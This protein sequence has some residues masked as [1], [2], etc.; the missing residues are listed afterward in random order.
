MTSPS[1]EMPANAPLLEGVAPYGDDIELFSDLY[2]MLDERLAIMVEELPAR[3]RP[4]EI[5]FRGL[6]TTDAE[7]RRLL[8]E[9]PDL[10]KSG[11]GEGLWQRVEPRVLASRQQG[12]AL[13][14][15]VVRERFLL[16]NFETECLV[17]C[18][19]PEMDA[20][21]QKLYGYLN[22]DASQR[23]PSVDLLLRLLAPGE[24]SLPCRHPLMPSSVLLRSGLLAWTDENA[25]GPLLGRCLKADPALVQFLFRDRKLDPELDSVWL[26]RDFPAESEGLWNQNREAA[27][28]VESNLAAYFAQ[29]SAHRERLVISLTGRAGSGR[30]YAVETSCARLGLGVLALDCSRLMKHPRLEPLLTRAFCYSL[31]HAAPLLLGNFDAVLQN[32]DRGHE[33]QGIL[34]RLIEE[35]GWVLFVLRDQGDSGA[36][37]FPRYRHVNVHFPDPTME[38]RKTLWILILTGHTSLHGADVEEIAGA[39][40]AKF[41]LTPGQI[42]IAFRKAAHV[43]GA[44]ASAE[45]WRKLLHVNS[46]QISTPRLGS[47]AHKIKP[48]YRA[49]QLILPPARMERVRD[50]I[51]HVQQ[52]RTV[53]EQWGFDDL[54]SR[55]KGLTVLFSGAPGTGKTMAAEVIANEL[56]MDLY[57]IDLAGV[58]SKY[59]G[60][61]EKNLSRI[62]QEA[63]HSDAILFFDEADALFGKRSE[64]KDAHDRYANIEINYL[65]QQIENFEG[66][67]ILATNM[68]QHLDEAFLR[69]MQ[70][71]VEFPIPSYEDR[72]RIWRQCVPPE[73]PLSDDV[74]FPFLARQFELAGGYIANITLW[75]ALLASEE[76]APIGMRHFVVATRR[77]F[78]KIG[79]RC[80][81][82]E[83]GKYVRLLE[84]EPGARALSATAN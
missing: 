69:R 16:S 36:N 67:A 53:M 77:E 9:P 59:I 11:Q 1:H 41:R 72:L 74:D 21:Y 82:E 62:F 33:F 28:A 23:Y 57:R 5:A 14:L 29:E 39:L 73:A 44:A 79:R 70:V 60:E 84:H 78:E 8:D 54:M 80:M 20:K 40:A 13:A 64:V 25:S 12:V 19:A 76:T 43:V 27:G 61:T 58:V 65:L 30:R 4:E 71:V 83:F 26:E 55:G 75:S 47:L 32:P 51:R 7:A 81:K 49:A 31:L 24:S 3:H 22:D 6:V 35:R 52:K 2:R 10:P 50:V 17:A 46:S 34:S 18:V 48:L 15:Q 37:W 42:A 63:E 45:E 38:S 66:V 56:D 68:R